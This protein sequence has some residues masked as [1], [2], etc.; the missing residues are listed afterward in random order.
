MSDSTVSWIPTLH[1]TVVANA[2]QKGSC[3]I[4][5][6]FVW[7]SVCYIQ[8][9]SWN[10][11]TMNCLVRIKLEILL[12]FG[13]ISP[14]LTQKFVA[15]YSEVALKILFAIQLQCGQAN[16]PSFKALLTSPDNELSSQATILKQ[17][18]PVA[19]FPLSLLI[20]SHAP[21]PDPDLL[22]P[23]KNT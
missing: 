16:F 7:I 8:K 21:Q 14:N 20:S 19:F 22:S 6:K 23:P 1:E 15:R 12:I 13:K 10:D 3:F 2:S 4:L 18:L 5:M 17:N 9:W 11:R